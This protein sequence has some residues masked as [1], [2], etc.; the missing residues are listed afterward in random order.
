MVMGHIFVSHSNLDKSRA[1]KRLKLLV[2]FFVELRLPTWIDRPEE[3]SIAPQ[4]LKD[5]FIKYNREWTSDIRAALKVCSAGVGV[6]SSNTIRKLQEDP[7]GV[8]FQE[9]N[10][11]AVQ[12]RLF[13]IIIDEVSLPLVSKLIGKLAEDQQCID[14]STK[15]ESVFQL[16]IIELLEQLPFEMEISKAEIQTKVEELAKSFSASSDSQHL[17]VT[18]EL[19]RALS[20][21]LNRCRDNDVPI[22]TYHFLNAM[23]RVPSKF[24]NRAIDMSSS[25]ASRSIQKW[26]ANQIQ[27]Q[28]MRD[29]SR[30]RPSDYFAHKISLDANDLAARENS[31][32]I[33]ERHYLLSILSQANSGSVKEIKN[34]LGDESFKRLIEVATLTKPDR[35]GKT[36]PSIVD[37][38]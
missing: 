37:P 35:K 21:E 34:Y 11:L 26:V 13:L 4:T 19:H 7:S 2:D 12:D 20:R 27:R 3:L 24:V 8:L 10:F 33:D 15:D 29:R 38:L 18:P 25:G 28:P 17:P 23:L 16:R 32:E 31:V 22:R 6:W 30:Q 5:G 36:G 9:L 14:L 1:D